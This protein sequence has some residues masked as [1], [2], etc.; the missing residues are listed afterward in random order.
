[1]TKEE[2]KDYLWSAEWK[3]LGVKVKDIDRHQC[4]FC[5]DPCR[6][7]IHHTTYEHDGNE[8]PQEL[9]TLCNNCHYETHKDGLINRDTMNLFSMELLQIA[10]EAVSPVQGKVFSAMLKEMDLY[11]YVNLTYS[12]IAE[13]SGVSKS[14]VNKVIHN[15]ESKGIVRKGR[16]KIMFNPDFVHKGGKTAKKRLFDKYN[17]MKNKQKS[18][19]EEEADT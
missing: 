10:F 18:E 6:L 2:Y 13:K 15:L 9:I 16:G 1:M 7:V 3:K 19:D 5:G 8:D 4:A 12:E 17:R 14:V 11:N